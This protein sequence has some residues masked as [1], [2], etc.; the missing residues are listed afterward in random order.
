M[1][2]PEK[3]EKDPVLGDKVPGFIYRTD[4]ESY[5]KIA[6]GFMPEGLGDLLTWSQRWLPWLHRW[7][8]W[9]FGEEGIQIGPIPKGTPVS[10]LTNIDLEIGL[11]DKAKLIGVVLD[12][13]AKLKRI[14][15]AS[16]TEAAKIFKEDKELVQKL[17]ELSKC[18]DYVVNKGH[19]FGTSFF[20]EEPPLSD[21][22]RRALI[23]FLKT[24]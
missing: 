5:I 14:A 15:G 23:E 6:P 11:R 1:L 24:F 9:L 2:W 16:E 17:I 10:L 4:S 12:I 18:P 22:D 21:E 3:R 13:K 7:F 8:P 19:Y 20:K